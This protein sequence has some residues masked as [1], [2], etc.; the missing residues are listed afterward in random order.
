[1]CFFLH[2]FLIFFGLDS[3]SFQVRE[4]FTKIYLEMSFIKVITK[5]IL[6]FISN[7]K[8]LFNILFLSRITEKRDSVL[9]V[10]TLNDNMLKN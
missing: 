1:M 9:T 10:E 2:I 6:I 4:E 3:H 5:N 7:L 8:I